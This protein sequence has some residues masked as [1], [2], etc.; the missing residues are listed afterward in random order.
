MHACTRTLEGVRETLKTRL[1]MCI[2]LCRTIGRAETSIDRL[3]HL[4]VLN[5]GKGNTHAFFSFLLQIA[6]YGIPVAVPV[7]CECL[8]VRSFNRLC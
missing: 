6:V 3:T 8:F 7:R 1:Q 4:A 2:Q 5:L